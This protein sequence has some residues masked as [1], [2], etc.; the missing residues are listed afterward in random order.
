MSINILT[1]IIPRYIPMELR[2]ILQWDSKRQII[3]W[4]DTFYGQMTD[5][6]PDEIFRR[7]IHQFYLIYNLAI[8][9]PLPL[10]HLSFFLIHFV[11]QQTTTP[12]QSQTQ[13]NLQQQNMTTTILDLSAFG[14]WFKFY[15]GFSTLSKE[16][17]TFFYLNIIFNF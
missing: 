15:W 8:D 5:G 13:F 4:H 11:L 1:E 6:M 17:Y 7:W 16:F 14:F 10:I 12:S 3:R 9:P 2:T